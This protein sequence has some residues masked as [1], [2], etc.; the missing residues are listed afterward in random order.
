MYVLHDEAAASSA[1]MHVHRAAGIINADTQRIQSLGGMSGELAP[2]R[3][4]LSTQFAAGESDCD[5]DATDT[6]R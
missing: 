6:Q 5:A 1:R 3:G 2:I 4:T